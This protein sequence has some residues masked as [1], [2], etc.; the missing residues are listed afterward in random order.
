[1]AS[2]ISTLATGAAQTAHAHVAALLAT[3]QVKP[4]DK[5]PLSAKVKE[6]D[7]ANAI[8]LAPTGR[9]IY[10]RLSNI[11]IHTSLPFHPSFLHTQC[12]FLFFSVLIIYAY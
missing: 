7:A 10:V 8:T 3:R 5:L 1:M 4:G 6:T 11:D 12:S 2:V 9:N